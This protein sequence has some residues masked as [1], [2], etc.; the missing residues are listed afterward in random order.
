M[1]LQTCASNGDNS[2]WVSASQNVDLTSMLGRLGFRLPGWISPTQTQSKKFWLIQIWSEFFRVRPNP[3]LIQI[4]LGS[5]LDCWDGTNLP[6]LIQKAYQFFLKK[7]SS[8]EVTI[9]TCFCK[10]AKKLF[11]TSNSP[12]TKVFFNKLTELSLFFGVVSNGVGPFF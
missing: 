6:S 3:C 12:K 2:S 4:R 5:D 10:H 7:V 9:I 11:R 8:T 1:Q